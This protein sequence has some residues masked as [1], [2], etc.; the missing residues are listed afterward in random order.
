[1]LNLKE[2]S[3]FDSSGFLFFIY[4]WRK[5]FIIVCASALIASWIFSSSIFITPKYRSSVILFP[6]ATNSVSKVLISQKSGIKEDILGFGEEEQTEQLL[7]ILNSNKIRDRI[8]KKFDLMNHYGINPDSRYKMTKLIREYQNNITFRRTEYMA[9]KISVLDKDPLM[10]ANIANTISELLDSTKNQMQKERAIMAFRIVEQEYKKLQDEIREIVDS[11]SVIG[12]LG[13]NDY[14]SQSEV[15]N[16]QFAI[17]ISKNDK[18]AINALEKRLDIL[19]KYG[20]TY[21]SLKNILEFKAEQLTLFKAKYVEA[22]IDAEQE[23]PQKF[24]VNDAFAAEK[25][26]YPIRWIIV[27]VSTLSAFL[28]TILIIIIIENFARYQKKT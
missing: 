13:V 4:K 11:L 16:Q 24:V 18:Q 22:K 8:I 2:N 5:P 21:L 9:V 7:Q 17:A 6:V 3:E 19:A 10:A 26:S 23:L 27:V 28:L 20:S 1:M 25:K 14:E 12:K 15:I